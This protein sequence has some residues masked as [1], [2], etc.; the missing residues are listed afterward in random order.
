V[1]GFQRRVRLERIFV[2]CVDFAG[3]GRQSRYGIA[4]SADKKARFIERLL[5]CTQESIRVEGVKRTRIP[6]HFESLPPFMADH[7]LS[8]TTPAPVA[9]PF[10]IGTTCRTPETASA[11]LGSKLAAFPPT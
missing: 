11:G 8:A 1:H 4:I 3:A 5:H 10:L 2:D 7:V 9:S 6:L